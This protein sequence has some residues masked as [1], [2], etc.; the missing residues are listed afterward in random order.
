MGGTERCAQPKG[1]KQAVLGQAHWLSLLVCASGDVLCVGGG[2]DLKNDFRL[3]W[4]P[5]IHIDPEGH[6]NNQGRKGNS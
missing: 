6:R 2:A 3:L 5:I 1:R 4:P